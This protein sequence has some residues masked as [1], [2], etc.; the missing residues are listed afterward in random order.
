[1]AAR[2]QKCPCSFDPISSPRPVEQCHLWLATITIRWLYLNDTSQKYSELC[3]YVSI[4]RGVKKKDYC[5]MFM[6]WHTKIFFYFKALKSVTVVK[7]CQ[8]LV[9]TNTNIWKTVVRLSDILFRQHT[10][11][12]ACLQTPYTCTDTSRAPDAQVWN[13]W[14][15]FYSISWTTGKGHERKRPWTNS[16]HYSGICFEELRNTA[17]VLGY[18]F[19]EQRLQPEPPG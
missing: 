8:L 6:K 13:H 2:K 16:R 15:R 14:L 12:A 3:R 9:T 19:S 5:R 7:R 1:M 4:I 18:Q 10:A 11:A 17:N